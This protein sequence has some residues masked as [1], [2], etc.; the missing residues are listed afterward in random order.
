[1]FRRGLFMAAGVLLLALSAA[2]TPLQMAEVQTYLGVNEIR[3]ESGEP[4]LAPDPL[5]AS[6]AQQ[7]A[8]DMAA[9]SYFSHFPPDGCNYA[10]LIDRIEGSHGFAG[11]NLAWNLNVGWAGAALVA[12]QAWRD[13]PPHLENIMNCHYQRF[14]TGVTQAA[15]NKIYFAMIFEGWAAC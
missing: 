10:C 14:G 8:D 7:R 13:S 11:E 4:G 9:K 6:V 1:M 5:L 3:A 12:V 2:C 15:D